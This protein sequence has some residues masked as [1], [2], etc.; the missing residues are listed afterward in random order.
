MT[1]V[2][3]FV[4]SKFGAGALPGVSRASSRKLRP[5]S[6]RLSIS[7]LRMTPSTTPEELFTRG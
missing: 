7:S 1:S 5:L 2:F 6:G 4:G 3:D